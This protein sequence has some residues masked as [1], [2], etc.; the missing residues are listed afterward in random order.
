MKV[1]C[2]YEIPNIRKIKKKVPNHQP[3]YICDVQIRSSTRIAS[4]LIK[5]YKYKI[6]PL[7]GVLKFETHSH[8]KYG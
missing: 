4:H 1:S 3:D 6:A 2:D 5:G 8:R 7:L